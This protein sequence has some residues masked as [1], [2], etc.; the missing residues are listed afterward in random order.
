[1]A[2]VARTESVIESI[3]SEDSLAIHLDS[4]DQRENYELQG[5]LAEAM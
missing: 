3:A 5:I 4:L 1:M 2:A